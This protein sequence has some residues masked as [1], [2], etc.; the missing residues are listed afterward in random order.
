MNAALE[1]L[2]ELESTIRQYQERLAELR[3]Q[4]MAADLQPKIQQIRVE[5]AKREEQLNSCEQLLAVHRLTLERAKGEQAVLMQSWQTFMSD[6]WGIYQAI[7]VRL[8]LQVGLTYDEIQLARDQQDQI[9]T[10]VR[11]E[12]DRQYGQEISDAVSRDAQTWM[13]ISGREF[14]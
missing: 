5:I 9:V 6:A 11:D 13:W 12:L 7:K 3:S 10:R 8:D 14:P 2:E 1:R 4:S